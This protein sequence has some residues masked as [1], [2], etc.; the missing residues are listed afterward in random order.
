MDIQ[1]NHTL[2]GLP[3]TRNNQ[4]SH[5]VQQFQNSKDNLKAL[6]LRNLRNDIRPEDGATSFET[7]RRRSIFS[8]KKNSC[9]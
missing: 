2:H 5:L 3:E 1:P 7:C 9:V 4:S 6:Q 8:M